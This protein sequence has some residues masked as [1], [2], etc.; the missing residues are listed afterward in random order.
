MPIFFL[1]VGILLIIVAINDKMPELGGL[2]KEDFQPS[3]GAPSFTAWIIA[4]FVIGAVGY[5]KSLKPVANSFLVLIVIVMLL[6]NKGFFD[7]FTQA[8]TKG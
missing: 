8:I 4:I 3:G 2:I 7:K 6:S 1:A 5:V